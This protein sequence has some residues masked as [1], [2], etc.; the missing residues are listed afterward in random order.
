ML[1]SMATGLLPDRIAS[2]T[3]ETLL[4]IAGSGG[5]IWRGLYLSLRKEY[6]IHSRHLGRLWVV[7][8]FASGDLARW[9]VVTLIFR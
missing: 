4:G 8:N 3:E 7:M 6:S 2:T 9:I 1:K 5:A